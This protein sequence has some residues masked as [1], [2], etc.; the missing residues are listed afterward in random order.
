MAGLDRSAPGMGGGGRRR[1]NRRRLA[2]LSP[3]NPSPSNGG[4]FTARDEELKVIFSRGCKSIGSSIRCPAGCTR[5]GHGGGAGG[6]GLG[7]P[8]WHGHGDPRGSASSGLAPGLRALPC[9]ESDSPSGSPPASRPCAGEDGR[10]L[11]DFQACV[12]L[13]TEPWRWSHCYRDHWTLFSLWGPPFYCGDSQPAMRILL[14][15]L[16][17]SSFHGNLLPLMWTHTW[18]WDPHLAMGPPPGHGTLTW[19]CRSLL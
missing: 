11:G 19:P 4:F 16:G 9:R 10:G 2:L 17:N 8:P 3:G 7:S 14:Q 15:L 1:S 13:L 12:G 5:G 6:S 18:P